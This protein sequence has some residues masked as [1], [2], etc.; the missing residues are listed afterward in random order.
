MRENI[1]NVDNE[2]QNRDN[3]L[4]TFIIIK[5][6]ITNPAYRV[7]SISSDCNFFAI[8]IRIREK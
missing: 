1:K 4:S 5:G 6:V 3:A 7:S 8:D 2:L